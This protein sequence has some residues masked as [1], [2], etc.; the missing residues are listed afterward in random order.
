MTADEL[1]SWLH[2]TR[3]AVYDRVF[4]GQVPGVVRVGR[5]LYFRRADIEHWLGTGMMTG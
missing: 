2:C 4:R 5:R 1:A 3:R